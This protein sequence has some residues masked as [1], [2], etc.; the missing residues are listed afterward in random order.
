M[1]LYEIAKYDRDNKYLKVENLI[2]TSIISSDN[3]DGHYFKDCIVTF[4]DKNLR[5]R[6]IINEDALSE[7]DFDR[8]MLF[9]L[10]NDV[11]TISIVYK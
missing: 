1:N 3:I 9:F 6:F 4:A 7:Y 8:I 11:S 10:I 5:N 2:N